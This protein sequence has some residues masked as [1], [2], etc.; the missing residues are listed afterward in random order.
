M[1]IRITYILI[2]FYFFLCD[3]SFILLDIKDQ[4]RLIEKAVINKE[5]R[6]S[7]RVLRSLV[8]VRKKLN[9]NLL[10]NLIAT[11]AQAGLLI[12][13]LNIFYICGN[14]YICVCTCVYLFVSGGGVIDN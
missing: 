3:S 12:E 13:Y 7:S 6:Y 9:E 4:L 8:T 11:Y 10:V 1:I 14:E 2:T 5:P